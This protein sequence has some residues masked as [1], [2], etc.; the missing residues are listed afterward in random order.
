MKCVLCENNYFETINED[1][2]K[3]LEENGLSD[4]ICFIAS[5]S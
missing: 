5:F 3:I 1:Y 4:N 2:K